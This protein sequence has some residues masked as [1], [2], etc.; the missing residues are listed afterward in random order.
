MPIESKALGMS[1]KLKYEIW[2]LL[3]AL[4]VSSV[5]LTNNADVLNPF[6]NPDFIIY[7]SIYL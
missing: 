4:K 1:N 5:T 7:S 6:W 2:E 3:I